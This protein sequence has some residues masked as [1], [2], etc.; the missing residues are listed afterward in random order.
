ME[1]FKMNIE[2][3]EIPLEEYRMLLRESKVRT[4]D[5]LKYAIESLAGKSFEDTLIALNKINEYK[6]EYESILNKLD[7]HEVKFTAEDIPF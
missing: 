6:K 3:V 5:K 2:T 4:R 7:Q 1:A